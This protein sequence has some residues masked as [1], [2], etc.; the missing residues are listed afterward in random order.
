M[1]VL[2]P[3]SLLVAPILVRPVGLPALIPFLL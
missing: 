3:A 1:S 2:L